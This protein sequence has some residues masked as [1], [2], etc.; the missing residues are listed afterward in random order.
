MTLAN[1]RANG[2]RSVIAARANCGRSVDVNG[3]KA[4]ALGLDP[5]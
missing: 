2:V 3:V 1:I 5:C 4:E